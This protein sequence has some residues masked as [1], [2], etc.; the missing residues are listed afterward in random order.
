MMVNKEFYDL[1]AYESD[2]AVSIYMPTHSSGKEVNEKHDLIRFKNLLLAISAE[3]SEKGLNNDQ[4]ST[5]MTPAFQLLKEEEFWLN[6]NKGLAVFISADFFELKK[7][8]FSVPEEFH[9]N[10]SF[11]LTPLVPLFIDR[12]YFYLLVLS[13]NFCTLYKGDNLGMEKLEIEGFP[14]GVN[15]VI[16]F[17]EKSERRLFRGG[18]NNPG[19]EGSLH[20]HGNGLQDEKEYIS[21]YLKEA[22]QTLMTALLAN[23]NAPL[24]I[25]GVEYMISI[26]K[27]VSPYKNI[28]S[29]S[30]TGNYEHID[31]AQL[32]KKAIEAVHPYLEEDCKKALKN[33]YN[34]LTSA[35]TSSMPEKVIPAAYY[36]QVYDLFVERDARIWGT[37]N[38]IENKLVINQQK[39]LNDVCLVNKAIIKTIANGGSVHILEKKRMPNGA[40]IAASLRF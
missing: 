8:P 26:F 32:F 16:H 25:A 35:L 4:I 15:D 39:Q 23:E 10:S 2:H 20:G 33:Y 28:I 31:V 14:Q 37:F 9:V 34:Q 5:L 19:K 24:L 11:H 21:Q 40:V 36:K 12:P 7:V 17:E 30:L 6:L 38:E 13:K 18:G 22:S 27:Q 1:S 29:P 3:L